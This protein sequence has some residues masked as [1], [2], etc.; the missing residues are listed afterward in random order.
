MEMG[1]L[2]AS[3]STAPTN[4]SFFRWSSSSEFRCVTVFNSVETQSAA[5]T[6]PSINGVHTAHITIRGTK[7]EFWLDEVL[8]SEVTNPAGNPAPTGSSRIALGA[9]VYIGGTIPVLAPEL[10][11]AAISLW[12]NDLNTNKLWPYQMVAIGRGAHQ[13]A[14]T[15]FAQ[16]QQFANS[17]LPAAAALSNTVPSY[18]TPGGLYNV[19]TAFTA[20]QDNLLFSY[21]VPTG[22]QFF[23]TEVLTGGAVTTVLGANG[24]ALHWALAL[25][26]SAASL[27]TADAFATNV[28]GPRRVYLCTQGLQASAAVGT[29]LEPFSL[30]VQTPYVI[31]SARFIG[32]ILRASASPGTGSIHGGVTLG[33]YFE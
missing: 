15:P 19:T 24:A 32:V 7:I 4:G 30:A 9:R 14:V 28:Y 18:T 25:N 12:R 2:E 3:G 1:Y 10:H 31:D 22:F 33:G 8:V 13:S 21:Q 26:S 6:A 16:L 23:M 27:A 17:A 29:T 5:L 20:N 11:I